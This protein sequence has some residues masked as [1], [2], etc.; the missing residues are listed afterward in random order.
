[1]A[2]VSNITFDCENPRELATFWSRVLGYPPVEY[3]DELRRQLLSSGMTED[4][5][6]DRWIA[7]SPDGSG[8][9]LF[10]QRVPE[11]KERKNRVHLDLRTFPDRRAA[12]AEVDA[13]KD[14]V[15]ALGATV[16]RL[17]D[18]MWGPHPEYHW[19]LQDP[20]GNEFCIQ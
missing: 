14:R 20:E 5:L 3:P 17:V 6:A 1:M 12:P 8:P 15:V 4:Q 7:E 16:V 2:S 13:E 9:R 11:K 10:F 18:G 19:V